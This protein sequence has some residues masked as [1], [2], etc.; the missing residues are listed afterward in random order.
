MSDDVKFPTVLRPTWTT[1]TASEGMSECTVVRGPEWRSWDG[2]LIVGMLASRRV[3]VLLLTP[4]GRST[5][6]AVRA[7]EHGDRIRGVTLGPDGALYV[8]TD[9]KAGGDEIWRVV[10][11]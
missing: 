10:P 7:L 11:R 4:D 5:S 9:G 2:A 3:Q 6:L 8:V 1:G